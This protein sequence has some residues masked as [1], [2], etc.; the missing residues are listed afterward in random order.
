M[1]HQRRIARPDAP[2]PPIPQRHNRTDGQR[3]VHA[4]RRHWGEPDFAELRDVPV[5]VR[6]GRPA[7]RRPGR[8]ALARPAGVLLQVVAARDAVPVQHEVSA[9]VGAALCVLRGRPAGPPGRHRI[10][11]RRRF[12]GAAVLAAKPAAAHRASHLGSREPGRHGSVAPRRQ[13]TRSRRAAGRPAR[14]RRR[15]A[16]ARTGARADGQAQVAAGRRRRRLSRRRGA[17]PHR[18]AGGRGRR[19][20]RRDGGRAGVAHPRLRRRAVR[21]AARLVRRSPTAA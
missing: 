16:A 20:R 7:R 4:V 12:P 15:A 18:R 5:G 2:L 10:G 19:R 14:G 21:P 9:R 13:R 17:E 6:A 1:G 11:D 8:A 3:A